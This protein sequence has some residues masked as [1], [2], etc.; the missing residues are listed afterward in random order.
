MINKRGDDQVLEHV[1]FRP[2]EAGEGLLADIVA[3]AVLVG[4][5][6]DRVFDGDA[7]AQGYAPE[8]L[9]MIVRRL[10]V[11]KEPAANRDDGVGEN[12]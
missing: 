6:N 9:R 3:L 12:K 4:D 5:I 11:I 2:R 8:I 1:C 10:R 7:G